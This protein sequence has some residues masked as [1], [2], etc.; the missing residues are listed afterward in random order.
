[1]QNTITMTDEQRKAQREA[2]E[3]KH[4]TKK[5]DCFF[6]GHTGHQATVY[7]HPHRYSGVI[8]CD[9]TGESDSCEHEETRVE[10]FEYDTMRNGEH[11]TYEAPAYVCELCEETVDG[12]PR[13]DAYEAMVDAQID[14]ARGK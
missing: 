5:I 10:N 7:Q 14:E 3:D 4:Y 11:D 13:E 1:M 8:E 9:K 2:W 6:E 12:D